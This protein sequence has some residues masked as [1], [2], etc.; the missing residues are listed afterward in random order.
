MTPAGQSIVD[1][2]KEIHDSDEGLGKQHAKRIKDVLGDFVTP[3]VLAFI[4]DGFRAVQR[5]GNT[6]HAMV[7]VAATWMTMGYV[8]ALSQ[9]AGEKQ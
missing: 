6:D 9:L 5:H 4:K 2:V 8:A 7:M 3:D 1:Q